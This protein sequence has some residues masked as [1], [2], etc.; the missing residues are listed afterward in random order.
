MRDA[1]LGLPSSNGRRATHETRGKE[2]NQICAWRR[3]PRPLLLCR[4]ARVFCDRSSHS[5]YVHRFSSSSS[6]SSPLTAFRIW[7]EHNAHAKPSQSGEEEEEAPL[8]HQPPTYTRHSTQEAGLA[9]EQIGAKDGGLSIWSA[10]LSICW[11]FRSIGERRSSLIMGSPP[12]SKTIQVDDCGVPSKPPQS[13]DPAIARSIHPQAQ[14]TTFWQVAARSCL[15]RA[16]AE[17]RPARQEEE[18]EEEEEEQAAAAAAGVGATTSSS[19]LR[20]FARHGA[21]FGLDGC[22]PFDPKPGPC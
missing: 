10:G 13:I 8:S 17:A 3:E 15:A 20:R 2:A 5:T 6:S 22:D 14:Q 7:R 16:A 19:C 4:R 18:E 11:L 9:G 1:R 12:T 21:R